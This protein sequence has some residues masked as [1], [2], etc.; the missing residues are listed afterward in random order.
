MKRVWIRRNGHSHH[1]D[2][3]DDEEEENVDGWDAIRKQ[4]PIGFQSIG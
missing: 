3:N 1:K 4:I 2:N